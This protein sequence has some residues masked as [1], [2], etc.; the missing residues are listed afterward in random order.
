VMGTLCIRHDS[1][2]YIKKNPFSHPKKL[3]YTGRKKLNGRKEKTTADPCFEKN[4]RHDI[5]KSS[6][7]IWSKLII[8]VIQ[9]HYPNILSL[10]ENE[11]VLFEI[12]QLSFLFKI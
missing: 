8:F 2:I 11:P 1:V 3:V 7:P 4:A 10:V 5:S 12:S 6:G 9:F